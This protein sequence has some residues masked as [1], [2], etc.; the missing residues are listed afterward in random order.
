VKRNF[1]CGDCILCQSAKYNRCVWGK[2]SSKA[3]VML[4]GEAPGFN[5]DMQGEPFVGMAG[6]VLD[7]VLWRLGVK[8]S[9]LYVTNIFK[10]RPPKNALP[11]QAELAPCWDACKKYLFSEIRAIKPKVIVPMGNTALTFLAQRGFISRWESALLVST[12]KEFSRTKL[13]PAY[14]PAAVLRSAS[15]EK[16]LARALWRAGK[17]AGCAWGKG[18][19]LDFDSI[20]RYD[21]KKTI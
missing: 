9:E 1:Q 4:V 15:L 20:P 17:E 8:R 10:C 7:N 18:P 13:V 5:E 11:R 12:M 19:P 21:M 6:D 14:H 2:G 16:N 3:K